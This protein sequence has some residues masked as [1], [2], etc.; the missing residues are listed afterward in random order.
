MANNYQLFSEVIPHLNKKEEAFLMEKFQANKDAVKKWEDSDMSEDE[1]IPLCEEFGIHT[2]T[3]KGKR[4]WGRYFYFHS[5]ESGGDYDGI[6]IILTEFLRKFRPEQYIVVSWADTCS[7]EVAGDFGGGAI[8]IT[9]N[10]SKHIDARDWAIQRG[11]ELL[12]KQHGDEIVFSLCV[13]DILSVAEERGVKLTDEQ[14]DLVKNAMRGKV[15]FQWSDTIG[16]IIDEVT[17]YKGDK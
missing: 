16:V 6:E 3:D 15:D 13:D 17:D 5:M 8:I 11:L 12:N 1:P 2:D 14:M 7:K 4:G 9:A 10:G